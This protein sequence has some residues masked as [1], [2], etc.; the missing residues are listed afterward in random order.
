ML[1]L[2]DMIMV[3]FEGISEWTLTKLNCMPSLLY[4]YHYICRLLM[5]ID[6]II[7]RR[8]KC[9]SKGANLD[10][11]GE[12]LPALRVWYV[13][14]VMFNSIKLHNLTLNVPIREYGI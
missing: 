1:P 8:S 11:T 2:S 14:R 10:V 7:V 6:K 9:F 13:C 4:Y 3:N 5:V 12:V